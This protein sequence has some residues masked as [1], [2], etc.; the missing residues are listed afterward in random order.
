MEA[1]RA[2]DG[3]TV[4][5]DYAHKPDALAAVLGTLRPLTR[6]RLIC[7]FGCGG[8]RD[9]GKRPVMGEIAAR[10]A[11]LAILT[12][13][14]PRTE[15]PLKI[16]AE[17]EAGLTGAGLARILEA[18]ARLSTND[19]P[20]YL[21]EPDRRSAIAIAL[22]LARAGDV[23][24]IAGKGHEDYQLVGDKVLSFDDRAV[25]RDLAI[26]MGF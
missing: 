13:D 6:G 9:R 23:V 7:V 18:R 25:V 2:R 21:V 26:E 16:I 8:D 12:S 10:L 14:N 22:R 1:V 15:D 4:L 19:S 11:N 24:V 5:V 17:V 3:V 20:G